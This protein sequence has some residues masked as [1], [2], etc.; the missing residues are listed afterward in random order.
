MSPPANVR[1]HHWVSPFN[2]DANL[3]RQY[4]FPEPFMM[5]DSTLRKIAK[6]TGTRTSIDDMLHIAAALE[7]IG[8]REMTL[9]VSYWGERQPA[10][11]EFSLFRAVMS[12][13]FTFHVKV[14][15]DALMPT[16][17]YGGP[18]PAPIA[19]VF[20][21]LQEAGL[22]AISVEGAAPWNE[23]QDDRKR[24]L[25]RFSEVF[26]V[27]RDRGV[28][29]VVSAVD[30]GRVDFEYL[31]YIVNEGIKNGAERVDLVDSYSS[32]GPEAMRLFISTL[33][34]RLAA[35]TP[36]TMHVHNDFGLA[37]A[38]AIAAASA[39]AYPDVSVNGLSYRS[40]FASLEEVALSL[41]LLYGVKTG[42]RLDL[43]Q[44]LSDTVAACMGFLNPPMKAITG[45][46]AYVR[47]HPIWMIDYLKGGFPPPASCY[48]PSLVGAKMH[49]VWGYHPSNWVIRAKLEQMGLS[50]SEEQINEIRKRLDAALDQKQTYP[51]WVG[52]E[53]METVCYDVIKGGRQWSNTYC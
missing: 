46:H 9:N 43:L 15:C 13:A 5:I 47:D 11:I 6:T 10:P 17:Y 24:R 3:H 44:R 12:R 45:S 29:C 27:A 28:A 53:E 51:I 36:I 2:Y 7:E 48:V 49:M 31:I 19:E 42:L 50:A 23:A 35:P 41:E 34:S 22:Q 8:I 30:A 25:E 37:T 18:Y 38:A 20:D 40:G 39:G 21:T 16:S 1:D 4:D 32:L 33:K 26:D 14:Y 52:E